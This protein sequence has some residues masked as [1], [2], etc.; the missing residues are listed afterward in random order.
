VLLE[1]DGEAVAARLL[2][3]GG[4]STFFS[5]GGF[6]PRWWDYSVATTLVAESLR[7]RIAHGDE[8]VNFSMSPDRPKLRWSRELR[9]HQDFAIVSVSARSRA[10]FTSLRTIRALKRYQHLAR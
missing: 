2:L 7:S 8:N 5:L 9:M 6:D 1:V 3:H 4:G 10:A